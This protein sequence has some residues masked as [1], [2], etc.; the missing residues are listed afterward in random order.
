[1]TKSTPKNSGQASDENGSK[2]LTIS[3]A[4][5]LALDYF[6]AGKMPESERVCRQV[7]AVA[8]DNAEACHLL[9]LIAKEVG[10]HELAIQW[11]NKA[12]TLKPGVADMHNN[13]G[14]VFLELGQLATAE[15]CFRKAI[16]LHPDYA[17]AHY[18]LGIAAKES[19]EL[20][21]AVRIFRFAISLKPDYL[22]AYHNLGMALME[23]GELEAA[24]GCW[25]QALA[26][27]PD[28]AEAYNN[29]GA[30]LKNKGLR[31]EAM[32]SWRK[33]LELKPDYAAACCNLGVAHR[34]K[35]E[36]DEAELCLRRA[37]A[38]QPQFV[39]AYNNLGVTIKAKGEWAEAIACFRSAI[40]LKPD[41]AEAYS[42]LGLVF[43][44]Q[45][46]QAE[47]MACWRKAVALRPDF[48]EVY[49]SIGALLYEQGHLEEAMENYRKAL[50][51]NPDHAEMHNNLGGG[52]LDLGQIPEAIACF[53]RALSLEPDYAL[54]HRHLSIARN[55]SG[56]DD[57]IR[58]MEALYLADN[59]GDEQKI[60]LA[61]GLGKAL[62]EIGEY[63]K[64]FKYLQEGNRLQ[65]SN[66]AFSVS[67]QQDFFDRVKRIFSAEFLARQAEQG[68]GHPD[69]SVI[70]IVGMPRSGTTLVEQILASH[71]DVH[72]A[73]ELTAL[74]DIAHS[75]LAG[76]AGSKFPESVLE[77]AGPEYALAGQRYLE[78]VKQRVPDWVRVTDKMPYNFLLIGLIRVILPNARVIHCMRNPIDNGLSI[79]KNYFH[80][81]HLYAYDLS[82]IGAYYRL[83]REMME[84][85]REVLPGV[86]YDIQYE[87]LVANQEGET[88]GL[89]KHLGLSWD[90]ACLSFYKTKRRVAT[91]SAMQVRRPIYRDSLK[92]SERY[93]ELLDPLREALTGDGVQRGQA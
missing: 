60:H 76:K 34:E 19:G 35:G 30:A 92:L 4:L 89:L 23:K 77:L 64:A 54:A 87:E 75:L 5:A 27:R 3:Q 67:A 70:F 72:G 56:Y 90:D 58:S 18:N 81:E 69:G 53:Q 40:S 16:A 32:D 20:D 1:M 12:I 48:A 2:T 10:K 57:D 33:A 45:R 25:R 78:S 55:H 17:E 31:D 7:L 86:I 91:A 66:Y 82:E 84:H 37:I 52:Y 88:R 73:G 36:L 29:L 79:F 93:G 14:A 85:W 63:P 21:L 8:P 59:V 13:L 22:N 44:E 46:D 49:N 9:G 24:M 83:Y 11:L 15:E 39:E 50:E 38:L 47:A 65:R 80:G 42:N 6:Q 74:S 62:E 61:F 51:L 43:K 26:V 68:C 71:P 41:Y 28:Y